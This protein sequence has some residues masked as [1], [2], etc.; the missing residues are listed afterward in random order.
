MAHIVS[1]QN[2]GTVPIF[3]AQPFKVHAGGELSPQRIWA[4]ASY[5]MKEYTIFSMGY[6]S[7][8]GE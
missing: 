2:V 4:S 8:E 6:F 5:N 1:G 7:D 3:N